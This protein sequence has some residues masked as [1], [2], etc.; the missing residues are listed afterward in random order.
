MLLRSQ[1]DPYD[2]LRKVWFGGG[3]AVVTF[4]LADHLVNRIGVRSVVHPNS[5]IG[6]GARR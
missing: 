5:K 1:L 4:E 2:A 6:V 3:H